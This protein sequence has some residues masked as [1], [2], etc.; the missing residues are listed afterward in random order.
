MIYTSVEQLIGRTPLLQPQNLA[1][2]YGRNARLLVKI[3]G[4]KLIALKEGRTNVNVSYTSGAGVTKELV[5]D[6][7]VITPFPLT[8]AMFDPSIW[9]KG[10]FDEET[11]TLITGQYGFGGWQYA[12]GLDLSAFK[13]QPSS[14]AMTMPVRFPSVCSTRTITGA[15]PRCM[16]SVHPARSWWICMR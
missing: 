3:E 8:E 10:S 9:E 2:H 5:I 13:T 15:I 16:I 12:E 6:V 14:S 1:A 7:N 11:S 4:G